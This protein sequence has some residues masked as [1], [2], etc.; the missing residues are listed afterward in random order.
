MSGIIT[1][2]TDFGLNESYAG[3]MKG[4][5]L[6]I[7]P[8][9]KIVDIT[10]CIRPHEIMEA[11]LV[12]KASYCYFPL[13]TIHAVVV[14][15]GVGG[16]RRGL[17]VTSDKYM[18]VGPDNGVLTL[19]FEEL[20]NYTCIELTATHY[21]SKKISPTFHGRDI[22]GP[23]AAWLSKGIEHRHFGKIITDPVRLPMKWA[24]TTG[25]R[26]E[27]EVLHID[28]FGNLI[29]NIRESDLEKAGAGGGL[30]CLLE[31]IDKPVPLAGYYGD[32]G[33][34]SPCALVGSC[35]FLEVAVNRGKAADFF[36]AAV[37]DHVIVAGK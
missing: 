34:G 15:P 28:R 22:F 6:S 11:A 31:G 17:M 20:V 16:S 12:L 32:V 24:S 5:I 23:V 36:S 35:G 3:A 33:I 19:V 30:V 21:F 7:N 4:S 26:I 37:G 1:L 27:G 13:R 29:T 25:G 9:V 14:D 10:H 8:E 18:F 2:I